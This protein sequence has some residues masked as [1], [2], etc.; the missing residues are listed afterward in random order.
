MS[1][2]KKGCTHNFKQKESGFMQEMNAMSPARVADKK[3]CDRRNKK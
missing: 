3:C 1:K 2:M